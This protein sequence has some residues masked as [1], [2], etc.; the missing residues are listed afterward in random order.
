MSR[1]TDPQS[2]A[3]LAELV[4]R[5]A[6]RLGTPLKRDVFEMSLQ[7]YSIAEIAASLGYYERGV[8]RVRAEA[9]K[10]LEE[11]MAG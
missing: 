6:V 7:G 1:E 5:I 3:E 10:F 8:E 2:A 4:E 9:K 11:Q